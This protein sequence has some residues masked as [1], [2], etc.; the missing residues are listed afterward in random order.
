MRDF[1]ARE[2]GKKIAIFRRLFQL[3]V[4][5]ENEEEMMKI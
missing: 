1:Y 4:G 5:N 2:R 3:I